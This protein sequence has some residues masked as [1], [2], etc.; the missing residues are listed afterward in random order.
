MSERQDNGRWGQSRKGRKLT[1]KRTYVAFVN[2]YLF[3]LFVSVSVP[4]VLKT[5]F[6]MADE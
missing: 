2:L 6:Y 1:R 3:V 4:F 5:I